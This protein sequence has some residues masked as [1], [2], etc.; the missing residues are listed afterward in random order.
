M[1]GPNE[2]AGRGRG[3]GEESRVEEREERERR[4]GEEG[5]EEKRREEKRREEKRIEDNLFFLPAGLGLLAFRS[6]MF[7][8]HP[9]PLPACFLFFLQTISSLLLSILA[10]QE[11]RGLI[12]VPL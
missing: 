5:R 3:E 10:A 1:R 7:S 2:R 11:C 4:T 6:G 9:D 12:L 8:L